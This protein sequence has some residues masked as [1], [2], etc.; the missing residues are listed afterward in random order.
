MQLAKQEQFAKFRLFLQTSVFSTPFLFLKL[1]FP[2][3]FFL[4]IRF[5]VILLDIQNFLATALPESRR[6]P[7]FNKYFTTVGPNL[8]SK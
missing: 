8:A 7:W 2:R 6:G 5:C 3:I 4:E 1:Y